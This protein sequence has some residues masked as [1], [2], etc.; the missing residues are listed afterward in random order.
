M[1]R[2][3]I[4]EGRAR[5]VPVLLFVAL[6]V[7]ANASRQCA[8]AEQNAPVSAPA[9]PAADGKP[10]QVTAPEWI[11]RAW[12]ARQDRTK[13][14]HLAWDTKVPRPSHAGEVPA[15]DADFRMLHTEL[16]LDGDRCS[17]IDQGF[18][19]SGY[20]RIKNGDTSTLLKWRI[21]SSRLLIGVIWSAKNGPP[22][23]IGYELASEV[24]PLLASTSARPVWSTFRP[25]D[26]LKPPGVFRP[27][28][29]AT[30]NGVRCVKFEWL[31]TAMNHRFC[32]DPARDGLVLSWDSWFGE[33]NGPLF[34][35]S[36]EYQEYPKNVWVPARWTSTIGDAQDP[37]FVGV[38][39]LTAC[40]LN[41]R[42]PAETFA[43]TFPEGTVVIDR[44][45]QEEYVV[46][47]NGIK[48][49]ILKVESPQSLKLLEV[50]DADIDFKIEPQ[51]LK[52]ALDFVAARY[53]IAI[54]ID[55][56]C[57]VDVTTEVEC[58]AP[59]L[60]VR[61]L[62]QKLLDQTESPLNVEVRKGALVIVPVKHKQ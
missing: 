18:T 56:Q 43:T 15:K 10:G 40:T 16:W 13:L 11:L 25:T 21:G 27:I 20:S 34:R 29:I 5:H 61:E 41:Q 32:V 17:R 57:L 52:D 31:T 42:F 33:G 62:L 35:N 38:S 48:T 3:L 28:E 51:S 6:T 12:R 47:K 45:T 50:L 14:L 53:P 59:G 2:P 7:S 55:A 4:V 54:R 19:G 36:I 24:N 49:D 60:T 26:F 58:R 22:W 39:T 46:G 23:E 1:P 9:T 37:H 8:E 44:R 30:V